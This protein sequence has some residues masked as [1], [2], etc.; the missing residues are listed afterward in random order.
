MLAF[1]IP[2]GPAFCIPDGPAF[3]IPGVAG[4]VSPS[5]GEY[6]RGGVRCICSENHKSPSKGDSWLRGNTKE[7]PSKG[8]PR[9]RPVG[10]PLATF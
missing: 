3:C 7:S 10:V 2:D 8:V 1:C 4:K 5:K 6:I 9:S